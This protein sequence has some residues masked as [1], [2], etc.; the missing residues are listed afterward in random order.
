MNKTP[1]ILLALIGAVL[2]T[3]AAMAEAPAYAEIVFVEGGDLTILRSDAPLGIADPMGLRLLAGDQI[4]TGPRTS[5]ELVM[6]PRRSRLR[7]SENTIV[8][9]RDL[10]GNGSTGLELLYGRLRSKVEKVAS[11]DAPYRVSSRSF[12][13][14]VRGTDFGCDVLAARPGEGSRTKVYC[15][16]GSVEVKPPEPLAATEEGGEGGA[17]AR[18]EFEAVL[19]SAGSMAIIE[20]ASEGRA[21]E[22]VEKPL[23]AETS[24]FWKGNGFSA[25]QP[26]GASGASAVEG[27]PLRGDAT[28]LDL[29]PI[30]K[31][32]AA[33]NSLALG[34]T[35]LV[36][37]GLAM[38]GISLLMRSGQASQADGFFIAGSISAVLGLPLI[39]FSIPMDPLA[40]IGP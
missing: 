40:G 11:G 35:I 25:A 13:A 34:G 29:R 10:G 38:E 5:V 23:D 2:G 26:A 36:G 3:Q 20:S 14:G 21:V 19:V 16:E 7:L 30:R 12:I 24:D 1:A 8:T 18:S 32:M 39:I 6:M 15:F 22:L 9:I 37:M 31:A 4:Q 27:R 28:Q 33:K 17:E